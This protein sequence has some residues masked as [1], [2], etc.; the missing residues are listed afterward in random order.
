MDGMSDHYMINTVSLQYHIYIRDVYRRKSSYKYFWKLFYVQFT[1]AKVQ[2]G[3][4]IYTYFKYLNEKR[5]AQS[6]YIF[7][8]SA[9]CSHATETDSFLEYTL[10][11]QSWSEGNGSC[12]NLQRRAP[13]LSITI[14]MQTTKSVRQAVAGQKTCKPIMRNLLCCLRLSSICN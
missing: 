2:I 13:Y 5:N 4:F 11:S 9:I 12:R 14:I 7:G 8:Y 3:S 6:E 1:S 10:P